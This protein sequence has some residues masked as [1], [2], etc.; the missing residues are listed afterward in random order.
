MFMLHVIVI[1]CLFASHLSRPGESE[2]TVWSSSQATTCSVLTRLPHT[3]EASHYPFDA[4]RQKRNCKYNFYRL[5]LDQ[6]E[7]QKK[8]LRH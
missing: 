4:N 6:T 1:K 3:V 2:N 5:W 7:N 8:C